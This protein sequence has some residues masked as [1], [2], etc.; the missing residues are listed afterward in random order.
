MRTNAPDFLNGAIVSMLVHRIGFPLLLLG[1]WLVLVQPSAGQSGTWTETGDLITARWDHTAT[2]LPDGMV[3]VAGG[4]NNV[5]LASAE[6]Y[7]PAS[8][9]WTETG[10][11]ADARFSLTATLLPNGEVLVAGGAL[12]SFTTLA[13]A[14]LYG[15]AGGTWTATGSLAQARRDH[16]ATLLSNDRRGRLPGPLLRAY[17]RVFLVPKLCFGTCLHRQLCC[18][19]AFF[20]TDSRVCLLSAR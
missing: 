18:V 5:P 8:G 13:S 20:R 9:T 19:L 4:K 16:T 7:D 10:H 15:P 14:E 11:L 17:A 6:L 12:N 1:A 2:L 3:L